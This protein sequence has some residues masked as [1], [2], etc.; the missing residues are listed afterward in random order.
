M[1]RHIV[2]NLC[3]FLALM[4]IYTF[5]FAGLVTAEE[6]GDFVVTVYNEESGLPT[7]EANDIL[8]TSDGYIWIGSY[9]GLIRYDGNEFKNFSTLKEIPSSSIR[10]MFED[11]KGRLW[12]GT[13]D[14]GVYVYYEDEFKKIAGTAEND[15][16]CVRDFCENEDGRIFCASNSGLAEIVG[17]SISPIGE[18]VAGH[19]LYSCAIDKQGRLWSVSDEV[20]HIID[21]DDYSMENITFSDESGKDSLNAYCL[22][23]DNEG[24]ILIGT[25]GNTVIRQGMDGNVTYITTKNVNTHNKIRVSE[26]GDILISGLRGFAVINKDGECIEFDETDKAASVNS[27]I[28]DYEGNYWLASSSYGVIKYTRGCFDSPNKYAE[29]LSSVAINTVAKQN[30]CFYVG[31]DSGIMVYDESWQTV[32]SPLTEMLDGVRIRHIFAD[33]NSNVWLATYSDNAVICYDA[34]TKDITVYNEENG[35]ISN[36]ARVIYETSDKTIVIGTQLGVSYIKNGKIT[37]NFGASEGIEVTQILSLYETSDG[38]VLAGSDG[39]G[40]YKIENGVVTNY[41][42]DEGLQEGVV[43]RVIADSS[44]DDAY[45]VSAGSSLYYF[46]NE[47]FKKL[48]NLEK[49]AGSIFDFYDKD[50][51]LWI[52]QNSGIFSV[53]KEKLLA[54][55]TGTD[56]IHDFKHGLTGSLNANT[57]HYIDKDG[58]IYLATRNGISHFGFKA[59]ENNLPKIIINSIQTDEKEYQ[60]PSSIQISADNMRVTVDFSI[61]SFTDTSVVNVSYKLD[62]FEKEETILKKQKS[63]EIS[64][65]NLPGGSYT[66]VL[67]ISDPNNPDNSV[68]QR[69]VIVKG[70]K[71]YE[72]PFF[73]PLCI[74]LVMLVTILLVMLIAHRKMKLIAKREKEYKGIMVQGL[75]T[76]AR[77]IDAKDKYTNGHSMRVA[78]YSRELAKRMG[79][80]EEEQEKVY[81]IALVHDIGK[82]GIPDLILN[83][84]DLLTDK[85]YAII[86]THP[87]IGGEILKNFT[88][89]EG[90]SDG[91]SYHHERYDGTGYGKQLA[92]DEIPLVARIIGIADSYDAM[93]SDRCYRKALSTEKTIEELNNGIETQ[94]DPEIVPYMLDMIS[95]GTAPIKPDATHRLPE[96]D[97]IV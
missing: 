58:S 37:Q 76:L 10:S 1:K 26:N 28:C 92:G 57:W 49:G 20:V 33:S 65:T 32:D 30:G 54:G 27:A 79:M 2:K 90:A 5:S 83:K 39:G 42:F 97:N 4:F 61:L 11:S 48:D 75:E 24:N 25:S 36:R 80:S 31:H 9:G 60:H 56:M 50:G 89:L 29:D 22:T 68:E 52:L 91:A 3:V 12:I 35:L 70:K 23:A 74:I 8:Q 14:A 81:Y 69:V 46:E 21:L 96:F 55:E 87:M 93:S 66:F 59:M 41:S 7:G 67:K 6:Y 64:Y 44:K 63:G 77:T 62:G 51:K 43:L 86:K 84:P 40:I 45:F 13:N 19:T 53:D 34:V 71:F 78:I 18:G 95:D 85:E 88:A 94:F 15:F 73:I 47:Q 72:E 38:A 16:L 82:I 17:E